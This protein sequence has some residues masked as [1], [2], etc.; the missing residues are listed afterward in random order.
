MGGRA[1]AVKSQPLTRPRHLIS[2]PADQPRAKKRRGLKVQEIL[3]NGKDEACVRH[4]VFGEA[5]VDLV[6]GIEGLIAEVL[7]ARPAVIAASAGSPQPGDAD[8]VAGLRVF[9]AGSQGFHDAYNLVAR[10]QGQLG[11]F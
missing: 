3:G 9:N 11:I 4:R 1:E 5:A 2:P 6:T 8:P 7:P 10:H